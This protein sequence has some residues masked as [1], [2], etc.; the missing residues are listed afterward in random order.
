MWCGTCW[1][2]QTNTIARGAAGIARLP[3]GCRFG[4]GA[5]GLLYAEIGREVARRGFDAVSGR[6][7]VS[8]RRKLRVLASGLAGMVLPFRPLSGDLS[9]EGAFLM[10][11]V[12]RG[13][14]RSLVPAGAA[15]VVERDGADAMGARPVRTAGT[16]GACQDLKEACDA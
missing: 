1:K 7:V 3:L 15:A 2:R 13:A 9:P 5:A 6:A 16:A 11:A 4:I 12:L 8:G 14:P 10:E